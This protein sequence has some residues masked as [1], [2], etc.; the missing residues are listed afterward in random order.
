M[1]GECCTRETAAFKLGV[2]QRGQLI[3][4]NCSLVVVA[5]GFTPSGEVGCESGK[6]VIP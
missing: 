6:A 4:Q 5:A 3:I 1:S 2:A